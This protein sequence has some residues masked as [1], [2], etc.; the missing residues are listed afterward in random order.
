MSQM[1][2]DNGYSNIVV[3]RSKVEW[4]KGCKQDGKDKDTSVSAQGAT[5]WSI[6]TVSTLPSL[7]KEGRSTQFLEVDTTFTRLPLT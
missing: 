1:G 2:K 3:K 7:T 6:A 5:E 4:P